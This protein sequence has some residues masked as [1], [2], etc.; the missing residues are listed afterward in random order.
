MQHLLTLFVSTFSTLLAI[1]NPL[2]ALPIFLQLLEGKDVE[3]HRQVALRS[4]IY[5]TALLFFF[6]LFGAFILRISG[7]SL[8]MVRI[9]GGI[10][11]MR[12]G[13]DLFSGSSSSGSMVAV[14]GDG[15]KGDIAFVPL[16]MPLMCGPCAIA[17]TL[18]MTS[19]VKHSGPGLEIASI[20]VIAGAILA[21]MFVTYLCLAHAET[22]LARIGPLGI[23]AATRII[24]FFVAAMGGGL[25]FHGVMEA[26]QDYGVIAA[27]RKRARR[28]A[29][30][31][32]RK[33]PPRSMTIIDAFTKDWLHT[34]KSRTACLRPL[35]LRRFSS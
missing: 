7:V 11:L 14:S 26:L 30:S 10:I 16:A 12:I 5:A 32:A 22:L 3:G 34:T 20:G 29:P 35:T 31:P 8:S 24:G 13:F 21:T 33:I 9:V 4:C 6:L 1:I 28:Q 19:L 2:E 23:D 18:G 25:I 15:A 27:H 17:T